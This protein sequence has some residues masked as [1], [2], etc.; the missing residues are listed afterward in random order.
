M[1]SLYLG[2]ELEVPKGW[3]FLASSRLLHLTHFL[4]TLYL[5]LPYSLVGNWV[6]VVCD[7]FDSVCHSCLKHS[8][9]VPLWVSDCPL[10]YKS[11][12]SQ[13]Q[14]GTASSCSFYKDLKGLLRMKCS[15]AWNYRNAASR[16][17]WL[18]RDGVQGDCGSRSTCDCN[19]RN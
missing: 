18:K 5:S 10:P 7:L 4:L 9:N 12:S 13:F 3:V 17:S 16:R 1:E 19:C 14:A 11:H 8:K 6:P 15:Q 2:M